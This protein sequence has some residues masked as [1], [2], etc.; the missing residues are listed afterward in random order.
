M[1]DMLQDIKKRLQAATPGPWEVEENNVHR[2]TI[3]AVHRNDL[4]EWFD[5]WS[6]NNSGTPEEMDG[7]A[8]LIINAPTDIAFLVAKVEQL[9]IALQSISELPGMG[10]EESCDIALA[11]LYAD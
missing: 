2:G 7:N 6:P 9:T 1:G 4:K 3:T 10:Q 8:Q 11:A 5:I